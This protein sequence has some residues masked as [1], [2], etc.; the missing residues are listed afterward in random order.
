MVVVDGK[1]RKAHTFSVKIDL[2][3]LSE[4]KLYL[5]IKFGDPGLRTTHDR[6]TK[7]I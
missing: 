7:V 6:W 5:S 1:Q 3:I 2:V 4:F